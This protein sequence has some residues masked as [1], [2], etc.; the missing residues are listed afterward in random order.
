MKPLIAA[1]EGRND[2]KNNA[3]FYRFLDKNSE[4]GSPL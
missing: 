2:A 4:A 3:I 1:L